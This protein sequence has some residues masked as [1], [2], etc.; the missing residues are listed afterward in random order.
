MEKGIVKGI[1][2]IIAG[3][4]LLSIN[5]QGV[6]SV[7]MLL[8]GLLI[9]FTNIIKLM[10]IKYLA[11]SAKSIVA[12]TSVLGI[13]LGIL[14]IIFRNTALTVL[15]GV[16]LVA[17]PLIDVLRSKYKSEQLRAGIPSVIAGVAL[18]LIGPGR[19]ISL[20]LSV[21]GVALIIA[22]IIYMIVSV[23]SK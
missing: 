9:A 20:V 12:F 6:L 19:A 17:L 5:A 22:S 1:I 18:I 11:G 16:Y 4:L 2:G 15:I 23:L 14:L 7:M 13:A 8:I 3:A 10:S 21:A